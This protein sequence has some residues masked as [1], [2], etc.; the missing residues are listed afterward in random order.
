M[1]KPTTT[2]HANPSDRL[3]RTFASLTFGALT[4]R[5]DRGRWM[6]FGFDGLVLH[7]S[8]PYLYSAHSPIS[9]L[10]GQYLRPRDTGLPPL[11]QSARPLF[12][13]DESFPALAL[14]PSRTATLLEAPLS[15]AALSHIALYQEGGAA[16]SD[17][18]PHWLAATS[19]PRHTSWTDTHRREYAGDARVRHQELVGKPI[20]AV[21]VPLADALH[22]LTAEAGCRTVGLTKAHGQSSV[23]LLSG[24]RLFAWCHPTVE[25]TLIVYHPDEAEVISL[26]RQLHVLHA[27]LPFWK[28]EG[29]RDR[30]RD[31]G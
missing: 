20:Q 18:S 22:K 2:A 26:V 10:L 5:I 31:F 17:P 15:N 4:I 1:I 11:D 21:D 7:V 23:A 3:I 25:A 13:P 16:R 8:P 29:R 19:W 30:S 12:V 6:D 28:S 9:H 24:L 14:T 27:E